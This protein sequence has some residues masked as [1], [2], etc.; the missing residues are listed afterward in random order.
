MAVPKQRLPFS[1]LKLDLLLP[2]QKGGVPDGSG[3]HPPISLKNFV[4]GQFL[5]AVSGLTIPDFNP[6]S[7]GVIATI[8]R[9]GAA[10]VDLAVAAAKAAF[11]AWAATPVAV[12]AALLDRIADG[13]EAH[14]ED[15]AAMESQDCGKTLAMART[16]DIPRAVANF[17]FF[18][19]AIRHDSTG[20]YAMHD[21]INYATRAPLGVAGLI[22]PWNLPAYLLSWKIA[23]ALACGN[24]V[25]AKPSEITPRT[26]AAI[27]AIAHA[28]GLPEGVLNIVHGLGG[29]C[30]SALV[31]HPD[32]P[33]VSFTGGTV[34][35]RAVG[36]A[37]APLFKK[38]SLE[39]G[40]KNATG[41]CPPCR[42]CASRLTMMDPPRA[43]R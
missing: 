10:D 19:G 9:S 30:G 21:A 14:L 33:L 8:P 34:T 38:V 25:V 43:P 23:P 24:S 20:A 26:A 39:L 22:S 35:G 11:P 12:R 18:A 15:L 37:A 42:R 1:E 32:V 27:A 2:Q 41:A 4:G 7:G 16:V 5:P 17:R 36:L 28:A 31:S 40:G 3:E 29:E 13:I 6:A